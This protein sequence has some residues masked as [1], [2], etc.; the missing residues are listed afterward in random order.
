MKKKF[1]L[2]VLPALFPEPG[3][4]IRGIFVVDYLKAAQ[5][6]CDI[7]VFVMQ[8]TGDKKGLH[9]EIFNNITVYRYTLLN[10]KK[11]SYPVKVMLYPYWI[12]KGYF[13]VASKFKEIDLIHAHGGTLYGT[14]AA[15]VKITKKIPFVT[16]EHT[17]PFSKISS[18]FFLKR[19]FHFAMKNCS[20][21]LLVSNYMKHD[22]D[23]TGI[24]S[25]PITVTHN[26]VDTELFKP[27]ATNLS[28]KK[29]IL[30][31]G[32]LEDYKGGL[33][34]LKSFHNLADNLNGWT[35][36]IIGEGKERKEI[37]AYLLQNP[38]LKNRVILKGKQTKP[39]IAEEMK[40]A[41]LFVFPSE[42]ETFGI[43]VTEAMSAGLP[44]ITTKGTP[45]EEY[46]NDKCGMLINPDVE[47][48]TR[49]IEKIIPQLNNY[50]AEEIRQQVVSRFGFE[51]FGEHLKKIYNEVLCAE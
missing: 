20:R 44:V 12:I 47:S 13:T 48:I 24:N 25:A 22:V 28:N 42:H 35:L 4:E 27:G 49:A 1:K 31:A 26:P 36:T 14:I 23:Q 6:H 21:L 18:S 29:N 43:V 9:E 34:T 10:R 46:V 40:K 15:L 30:F 39:E 32:R 38:L 11:I 33:R 45:M 41:S 5:K 7:K 2:L 16:T 37:D 17:N 8:F 19:L 3:N 51:V 50:N